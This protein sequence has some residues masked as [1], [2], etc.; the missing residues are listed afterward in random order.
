MSRRNQSLKNIISGITSQLILV[1]LSFFTTRFIKTKLG[2]EYLGLNGVFSNIISFL[3]LTELGIGSAII[4][5][6]YKPL[7]EK[8]ETEIQSL[9]QFYKKAYHI[10]AFIVLFIGL[11]L[12]PF[13]PK[14]VKSEL[15]N[16]YI[17]LIFSLFLI[18][19]VLSYC[20]S[21]KQS[22]IS[23]DQK[24]YILT[25]YSLLFNIFSKVLQLFSVI[26]FNSYVFFL[27]IGI[28]ST[29]SL[30][31]VLAIKANKLYPYL[32][33]KEILPLLNKKKELI[34]KKTK[35]M[36][37][38]SIG[39]FVISGTDNIIIS[40]FLGVTLVG[41]YGVYISII[42]M[43][44]TFTEQFFN[45]IRSSIGNYIAEKNSFEQYTL[46][47]KIENINSCFQIF[48]SVCLA[49][50]FNPF[51]NWWLGPD[52]MLSNYAV[53]LLSFNTFIVI[54]RKPIHSFKTTS[55]L[56]EK[57]K[58]APIIESVLNIILSILLVKKLGVEGVIIGTIV[59]CLL[60]PVWYTPFIVFKYLFHKNLL[61]YFIRHIFNFFISILLIII[62]NKI[63]PL[64]QVENDFFQLLLYFVITIFIT[65]GII[66]V[67][68]GKTV[69]NILLKKE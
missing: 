11:L 63:L 14:F 27:I 7:A 66:L 30:N 46:Y 6:L 10:I 12:F 41:K 18:N 57:D 49:V 65:S 25:F 24:N 55:G 9:M 17:L 8:N 2:F 1:L 67:F 32:K 5:A 64:I 43:V 52:A 68:Y 38:H 20:L 37:F 36:F 59:S 33:S 23:A 13:I 29:I 39:T 50:L 53:Y 35:A 58:Y 48:I 40:S 15:P 69:F 61:V 31:I 3:S 4:F 34:I 47:K 54:L 60:V 26:I 51:I 22:L 44:L 28:V 16:S 45:G 42:T 19:S 56:F 62:L 21:Y